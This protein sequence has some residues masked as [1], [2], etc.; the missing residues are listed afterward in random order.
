MSV[1]KLILEEQPTLNQNDTWDASKA[2]TK[3]I[4]S[5]ATGVKCKHGKTWHQELEDK[6][7]SIKTHF[8]GCMKNCDSDPDNLR[9]SFFNA[10]E[11]YKDHY[12][13]VMRNQGAEISKLPT[14]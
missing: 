2:L 7:E 9:A 11:H 5:V 3:G 10:V 6:V 14:Q 8:H 1:N 4:K 13:I 12:D